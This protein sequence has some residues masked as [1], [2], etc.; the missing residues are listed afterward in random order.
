MPDLAGEFR[1]RADDALRLAEA[2]EVAR[3]ESARGS[4]T[5]QLLHPTRVEALYELAFLRVFVGW[6]AFLE[7]AFLRFLCGY[8][9]LRGISVIAAGVGTPRNLV[10]A[11][12]AVLGAN[13]YVLWHNPNHVVGRARRFF[14]TS[15]LETTILS[16][17]ARLEAIASVR[18]RI[19]HPQSDARTKFDRATM[20]LAGRRYSGSRPGSF[21]RDHDPNTLPPV[22]WLESLTDELHAL[23]QQVA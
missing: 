9:S 1:R 14:A 20:A 3:L 13:A 12:Q 22:R 2:G 19:A 21:L 18:H 5:R 16:N 8:T 11:E 15:S 23:A 6:E 4:R 17:T 7:Q 10:Q